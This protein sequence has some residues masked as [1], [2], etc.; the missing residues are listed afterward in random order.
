MPR[1]TT[2]PDGTKRMTVVVSTNKVGSECEKYFDF[3]PD[4]YQTEDGD[5]DWEALE[6]V[7]KDMMFE[8]IKWDFYV[9]GEHRP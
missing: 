2:K 3:D 6:D 1:I 4:A 8:M 9:D 7:A 5:L